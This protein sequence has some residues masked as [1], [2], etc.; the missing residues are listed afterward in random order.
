MTVNTIQPSASASIV[1][2]GDMP[3][4]VF[5]LYQQALAQ[6]AEGVGA[7]A[8]LIELQDKMQRRNAELEFSRAL[9]EF[10]EQCPSIEKKSAAKIATKSGA[11]YGF[12]YADL[13]TIIGTV[14][15][16]LSRNGFSFTFD[17]TATGPMLVCVCTLHHSHGHT[18]KSSFT[19]P[20]ES[21]SGAS[22]QQK[23]GGALTYAKRQCLVSVLGLAL[24]D[25]DADEP[26]VTRD[27]I[28]DE[29]GATIEA[30]MDE[31]GVT[32]A[33]FCG[34]FHVGMVEE[35]PAARYAEAVRL[36]EAKRKA[37]AK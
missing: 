21:A 11:S 15:P 14:R 9:A 35:L 36:L 37:V 22:A 18:M 31:V 19:V 2:Q 1:A 32:V 7:L 6:G 4:Q 12:T 23:Y 10:Q 8:Q 17:S 28:T 24:T 27:T 13:E 29:Q 25:V 30:L 5:T 34:R 33:Q 20:T 16:H 26:S 3:P